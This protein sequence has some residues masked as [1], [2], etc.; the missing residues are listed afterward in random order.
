MKP[1]VA[2]LMEDYQIINIRAAT[3]RMETLEWVVI[4]LFTVE[5]VRG[6]VRG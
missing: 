2:E 3:V 1:H 6:V 4:I 5:I